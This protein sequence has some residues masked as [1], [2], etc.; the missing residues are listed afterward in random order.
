MSKELQNVGFVLQKVP[1]LSL[2]RV[3]N[4]GLTFLQ[5]KPYYIADNAFS[6]ILK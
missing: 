3:G 6:L 1:S 5:T 4:A 2:S